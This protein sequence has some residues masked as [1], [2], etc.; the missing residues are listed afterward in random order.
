MLP[1]SKIK[2]IFILPSL[3]AGGAERVISFVSQSI[4][5]TKFEPLL[6]VAGYENDTVYDVS[7]VKVNYLNKNRILTAIPSII[8]SIKKERPDIVVSS[9]AHV[10]TAMSLIS[11]FFKNT[12]FIGRE[13]TIL[14]KRKNEKK[15]RKFSPVYFMSN[16]FQ[17]LDAIICQSQDMA[18]DMV[19]NFEVPE[20]KTY[21]INN[22]I[23]NLPALKDPRPSNKKIKKY[24]TVGRLTEVKGH[25]RLLEIL[26]RLKTPFEYTIIGNG[27]LKDEI[28]AKA[29]SL[30]LSN[31]IRHIPFT[32]NVN[33]YIAEHDLFLQGSYVEGFP[34]ALLESCVVGTPVIAFNVP[35]GTKEIV[36]NGIN[37]YLVDS[38]KEFEEKLN[39]KIDWN[40]SEIRESVYKKFNKEK[41]INDYEQ[42]F[43]NVL[44]E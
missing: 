43:I 23:S 2:I 22:P 33:D 44:K 39:E 20:H 37:G 14:S 34:N 41:I 6:L 13:A 7:N 36:E 8:L 12:K 15:A 32:N 9:I 1:K 18:K 10:N 11:P 17:K 3:V 30:G 40:P 35:G 21:V 42:L 4:D 38:E 16:G 28:F 25:L 5:K 31:T 19:A 26:S 27:G 24:I 29:Q